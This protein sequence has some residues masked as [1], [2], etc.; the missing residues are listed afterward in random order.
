MND[1]Y[2]PASEDHWDDADE[3][4]EECDYCGG[5]GWVVVQSDDGR[6]LMVECAECG[7][8]GWH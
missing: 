7:G 5:D 1:D 8:T 4:G 2:D 3:P 6:A